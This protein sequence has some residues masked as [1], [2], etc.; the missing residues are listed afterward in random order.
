MNKL[1]V[2]AVG[3]HPDDL[4]LLCAGT[5]ARYAGQGHRVAMAILLNGDKG[6]Y[7]I[8][9]RRLAAIR[10]REAEQ[11]GRIIGAEVIM[12][13]I[14]DGQL[15]SDLATR[16]ILIDL[17][18]KVRPDVLITHAPNDYMSDHNTGSQAVCDASFY[19][20]SPLFKTRV[21]R[22][23]PITPI[24]FM[25]TL[26]GVGFQPA[27]YVDITSSMETKLK[28][29]R[30]HQSQLAWIKEHDNADILQIAETVARF[31]G[32]QCGVRY[33]EGFRH[34]EAWGRLPTWRWLP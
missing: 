9:S 16:R 2:L 33:A 3:A 25:D 10:K 1:T 17:V 34:H 19:A 23:A 27:E 22:P 4:E 14:P 6:H 32:L 13:G 29:L 11:S 20:G 5:L 15:F 8:G 7:K 30:C 31:R 24:Y 18:R 21:R 26:A 28:M 12:L